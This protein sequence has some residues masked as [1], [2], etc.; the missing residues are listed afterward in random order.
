VIG[1]ADDAHKEWRHLIVVMDAV[2][3][4]AEQIDVFA[5]YV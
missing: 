5:V 4:L 2:E 1:A 3:W